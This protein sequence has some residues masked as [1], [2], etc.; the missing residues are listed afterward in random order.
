MH[1]VPAGLE[2]LEM[3]HIVV[4]DWERGVGAEQNVTL[5]SI[6]SIQDPKLAPEGKHTL[7][8]YHPATEPFA[9][10]QH[11]QV[12]LLS[13]LLPLSTSS[14]MCLLQHCL[15]GPGAH[16]HSCQ[17]RSCCHWHSV[18]SM[19][20]GCFERSVLE[21]AK[22]WS[23]VQSKVQSNTEIFVDL[24]EWQGIWFLLVHRSCADVCSVEQF[25][26]DKL[27]LHCMP[28]KMHISLG[29]RVLARPLM[30]M[31]GVCSVGHLNTNRRSRSELR[32]CGG[33][34]KSVY[35]IFTSVRRSNW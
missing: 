2:G 18:W 27:F 33:Q 31:S 17:L 13:P 16:H 9:P 15:C 6:A 22:C 1:D 3:H 35:L 25:P 20:L 14:S 30:H 5:V 29:R 8:A 24:L 23:K 12:L 26:R 28:C 4:E 10:W 7:H 32:H 21:P 34:S 19:M 11:L